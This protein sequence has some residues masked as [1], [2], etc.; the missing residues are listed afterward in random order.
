MEE[1]LSGGFSFPSSPQCMCSSQL[2]STRQFSKSF[3]IPQCRQ[4]GSNLLRREIEPQ[5]S[6]RPKIAWLVSGGTG[7][8]TQE[9]PA[10]GH[11]VL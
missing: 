1:N 4:G 11:S 6:D 9:L 7:T 2:Y 10:Q 8:R 5:S 3:N